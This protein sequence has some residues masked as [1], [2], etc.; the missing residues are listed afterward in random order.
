MVVRNISNNLTLHDATMAVANGVKSNHPN[1]LPCK[2]VTGVV[3]PVSRVIY[4]LTG[5]YVAQVP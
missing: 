3:N 4:K 2:S 5:N 1:K